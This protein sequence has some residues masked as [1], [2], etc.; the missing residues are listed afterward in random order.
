MLYRQN[1]SIII[2]HFTPEGKESYAYW[3]QSELPT[4]LG[5]L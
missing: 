2:P 4:T 3:G 5:G 1:L